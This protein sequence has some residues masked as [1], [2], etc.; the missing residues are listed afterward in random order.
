MLVNL[1]WKRCRSIENLDRRNF[2]LNFAGCKIRVFIS[3]GALGH[4]TGY[5][6]N[7][8]IAQVLKIVF[9]ME[10]ALGNARAITQ[11]DESYAAVVTTT[12]YPASEG[13]GFSDVGGGELAIG[14][15]AKHCIPFIAG[16]SRL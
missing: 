14:M 1:E 4:L 8:L 12:S 15:G 10:H 2:N 6:Q 5:T 13:Y 11:I 7:V 16:T 9:I 3:L